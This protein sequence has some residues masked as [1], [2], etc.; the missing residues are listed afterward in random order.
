MLTELENP[1]NLGTAR[2]GGEDAC[3]WK[4]KLHEGNKAINETRVDH[5]LKHPKLLSQLPQLFDHASDGVKVSRIKC[6]V[7]DEQSNMENHI[8]QAPN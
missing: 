3:S 5:L 4:K 1:N 7:M 8:D 2:R 6:P